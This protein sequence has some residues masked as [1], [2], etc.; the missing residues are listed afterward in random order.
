LLAK[1]LTLTRAFDCGVVDLMQTMLRENSGAAGTRRRFALPSRRFLI[2][3]FYNIWAL[4][5]IV[6]TAFL[7]VRAIFGETRT[8]IEYV[9]SGLHWHVLVAFALCVGCLLLRRWAVAFTL[10]PPALFFIVVYGPA[11]IPR[12]VAQAAPETPTLTVMTYNLHAETDVLEPMLRLIRESGADVVVLQEM[13]LPMSRRIEQ[14][15]ADVYPYRAL[16]PIE[17]NVYNGRGVLSRYPIIDDYAWRYF[18]YRYGIR[19]QRVEMDINGAAVTLY[20]LHATPAY[21][22]WRPYDYTARKRQIREMVDYAAQDNGAVILSGDFN[23][24]ELSDDYQFVL[25]SGY[26]D[27]YREAGYGLG[28]TGGDFSTPQSRGRLR[29]LGTIPFIP[30]KRIDYVFHN[31]ELQTLEAHVWPDSGGSDH[32]P[33][34]VKLAL[35]S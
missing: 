35:T 23:A 11:F 18:Y 16:H 17:E 19:L 34:W 5:G 6:L 30:L 10:L 3:A 8:V 25:N 2:R 27:A 21:E 9:N 13:S 29:S 24:T 32:R 20:N 14:D 4:Y 33:L 1:F 7:I 31:E 12:S 15:L 26:R 22:S 28:W